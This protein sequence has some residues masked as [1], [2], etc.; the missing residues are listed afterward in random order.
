MILPAQCF[1]TSRAFI[2]EDKNACESISLDLCIGITC[3]RVGRP[4]FWRVS[5]SSVQCSLSLRL[6]SFQATVQ[7]AVLK[8]TGNQCKTQIKDLCVT[9]QLKKKKK[10]FNKTTC[11]CL[12]NEGVVFKK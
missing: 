7:L 4:L 6:I 3:L 2:D 11:C 5:I 10:R 8:K 1:L 9:K 12:V